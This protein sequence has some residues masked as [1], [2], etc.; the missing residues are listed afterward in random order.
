[1]LLF[2][3][4]DGVMHPV[5]THPADRMSRRPRFEQW[6]ARH[7]DIRFVIAS[8]WRRL[9][10]LDVLKGFFSAEIGAR[11]AGVTPRLYGD[12]ANRRYHE[13]S[14]WLEKNNS[15][16]ETWLALD[17]SPADFPDG[18]PQLVR[19]VPDRGFDDAV[20]EELDR[21]IASMA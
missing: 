21:R 9:Y 13:I 8:S 10:P 19:C 12:P 14:A 1:M 20:A 5:G 2:I 16:G 3:D 11:V 17:D 18:C 15:T 4:I 6:A 7:P